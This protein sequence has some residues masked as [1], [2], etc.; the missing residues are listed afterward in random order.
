MIACIP[1]LAL[2][3]VFH[4]GQSLELQQFNN[5]HI[6][7][8]SFQAAAGEGNGKGEL[9]KEAQ[10]DLGSNEPE[11]A[12]REEAQSRVEERLDLFFGKDENLS[13][14]DLFLKKFIANKVSPLFHACSSSSE[15]GHN[16]PACNCSSFSSS[17][18]SAVPRQD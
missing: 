18:C 16:T 8:A 11:Q 9:F 12:Q 10:P 14:E 13:Q 4:N 17:A 2:T 5:S 3:T 15:N 7:L 6:H 1:K